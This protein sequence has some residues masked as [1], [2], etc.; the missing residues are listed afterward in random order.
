MKGRRMKL[1]CSL[2]LLTGMA[3][4]KV[5]RPDIVLSNAQMER[6]LYDYHLAKAMGEEESY[7]E[8]YKRVLYV[9][10]VFKKH[11][12]TQEQFD[13][14]MVWFARHPQEFNKIYENITG[15]LKNE[16]DGINALVA[17]RDNKPV[18]S[19]PGDSVDLWL[20]QRVYHLTGMPLDNKL[21]FTLPSDSN[22]MNRDAISWE[23]SLL[24]L[25]ELPDTATHPVMALQI[26]YDKDSTV[27]CMKQIASSGPQRITLHADTLGRI[28]E[29]SG[30]LYYPTQDIHDVIVLK[31]V[32]LMRYHA[33]DTLFATW[34]DSL[35]T[36]S[37]V[38]EN[39][40]QKETERL[41]K[42]QEAA[43][44]LKPLPKKL[45]T[46]KEM[47]PRPAV[48]KKEKDEE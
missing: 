17:M 39:V 38:Q 43:P 21:T 27:S 19:Q 9:E 20:W 25:K 36:A 31:D 14:S 15:R 4:C 16:R 44:E 41:Q 18:E 6:V 30:F 11:G 34:Q 12:I 46:G 2:L 7:A 48:L 24:F 8:S 5:E 26:A 33:T 28:K 1:W 42:S 13:S 40:P 23:F 29:V 22:F 32:A 3:A 47:R 35:Q 45:P 10:A 37:K